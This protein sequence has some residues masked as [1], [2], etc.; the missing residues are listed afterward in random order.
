[1]DLQYITSIRRDKNSL[2]EVCLSTGL[3]DASINM[4]ANPMTQTI[5]H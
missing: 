1:M 5:L 3:N 4:A 2:L